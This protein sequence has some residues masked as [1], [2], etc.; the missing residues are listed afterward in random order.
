[1]L[2]CTTKKCQN[3]HFLVVVDWRHELNPLPLHYQKVP[4]LAKIRND[5][6]EIQESRS[7][8]SID[9]SFKKIII[10]KDHIM[11]RRNEEG[12]LTIGL[13]DFLL[14]ENSLDL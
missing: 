4:I 2:S 6:E 13:F 8:M 7:L 11:P 5:M 1:M 12:I 10:V 3:W 14:K 9:D